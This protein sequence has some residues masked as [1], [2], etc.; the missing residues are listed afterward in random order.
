M[1]LA[2]GIT[3][4]DG[5]LVAS[6]SM[7]HSGLIASH[8]DKAR[9][10]AGDR[11]VW[12]FSGATHVGQH[13]ERAIDK[14][15]RHRTRK[16]TPASLADTLL[17]VIRKAY[18]APIVPPGGKPADLKSYQAEVLLL[19]WADDAASL[20]HI[21]ADLA[22][23]ECRSGN[24]LAIGSGAEYAA[25]VHA[26]LSHHTTGRLTLDKA[27]LLAYRIVSTVCRV[28]S[29][30]VALPVQIAVADDDGA[31]LLDTHDLERLQTGVQRWLTSERNT[32]NGGSSEP[33]AGD[34]PSLAPPQRRQAN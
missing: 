4:S 12:A 2:L 20:V 5:V 8:L 25:V 22:P 6:D 7:G 11:V 3:C 16:C 34:L 32:F 9:A 15:D 31:G 13:V 19:G 14:A 26:A 17:P 18:A 28:S 29:W 27:A 21:P 10:L 1:T 23:V 24:F 30:G 33:A